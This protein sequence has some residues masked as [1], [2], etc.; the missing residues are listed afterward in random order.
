M[1]VVPAILAHIAHVHRYQ[2]LKDLPAEVGKD[3]VDVQIE[4][5]PG[6]GD[7]AEGGGEGGCAGLEG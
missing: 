4:G 2:L 1:A 3:R 5:G 6:D 7:G